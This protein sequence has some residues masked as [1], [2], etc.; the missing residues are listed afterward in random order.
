MFHLDPDSR[1]ID[2]MEKT[3]YNGVMSGVSYEGGHFFYANPLASFPNVNPYDRF[4]GIVGD[5]Y[6]RRSEWF[7]CP[8]C[9]P[10]LSRLVGSIGGYFY[11][12]TADT[13]YVH[14]YNQNQ[15]H[16]TVNERTVRIQQQTAYPWDGDIELTIDV[17][18]PAQFDL[19]L[20]IP[21]WCRE[22]QIAVNGEAV[23]LMPSNGYVRIGREWENGDKVTLLLAMPVERITANPH[24]RQDA[25]HI[26]LQRGPV[27]Y[28]LEEVD[29][30]GELANVV[31]P[32]DAHLYA[33]ID[34]TLFQGVG[35]I[36]GEAA[37]V[38]P[39]NWPG[40]LYQP[41]SLVPYAHSK[42]IF[43]AIPYCFW[44][45]REPGEMRVW[46]REM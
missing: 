27:V 41:K 38:E 35:V 42:F 14:L 30:G 25:G 26:A 31:I 43:K 40:G 16:L 9:P 11:T 37:R 18:Q 29:N 4:S 5:H 28:C 19:A 32:P 2:V 39:A 34:P 17:D 3:L 24:I 10:N 22:F 8:C 6:Y 33:E 12:T 23:N 21:G 44:A 15:A 45:N 46:I 36:T 13:L 20:R 7:A 1:Y